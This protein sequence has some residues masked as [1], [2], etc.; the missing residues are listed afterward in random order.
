AEIRAEARSLDPQ[1]LERQLAHME[2]ALRGTAT[3]LGGKVE[4]RARRNYEGFAL[5]PDSDPVRRA[6]AAAIATGVEP[7][8]RSTGG[9]SDANVF[10][11]RGIPCAV[12]GVGFQAIHTHA[13]RMPIAELVRLAELV[14]HLMRGSGGPEAGS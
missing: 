9:G 8:I 2:G 1:K 6:R 11:A 3:R 14:L 12:L 10:N 13:E 7:R 5:D 4:W